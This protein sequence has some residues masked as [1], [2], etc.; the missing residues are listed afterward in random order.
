MPS[1]FCA[2][3]CTTPKKHWMAHPRDP[4][5]IYSIFRGDHPPT[6]AIYHPPIMAG[7]LLC[8]NSSRPT[9]WHYSPLD[10]NHPLR[11]APIVV[12]PTTPIP[13]P[14]PIRWRVWPNDCPPTR[15]DI[16]RGWAPRI[17]RHTVDIHGTLLAPRVPQPPSIPMCQAIYQQQGM[18]SENPIQLLNSLNLQVLLIKCRLD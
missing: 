13:I 15:W 7:S 4:P 3:G 8:W 12:H 14:C 5:P 10:V 9:R 17:Q 6:G 11:I 18:G 2:T 1:P 16:S